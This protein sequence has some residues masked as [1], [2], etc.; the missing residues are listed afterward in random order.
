MDRYSPTPTELEDMGDFDDEDMNFAREVLRSYVD[1]GGLQSYLLTEGYSSMPF[2]KYVS[3]N[4]DGVLRLLC[5]GACPGCPAA[6]IRNVCN[7]QFGQ[8]VYAVVKH[9]FSGLTGVMPVLTH[10]PDFQ[11]IAEGAGGR[12]IN[13]CDRHKKLPFSIQKQIMMDWHPDIDCFIKIFKH[14]GIGPNFNQASMM[15]FDEA[16]S[17]YNA[18]FV[19]NQQFKCTDIRGKLAIKEECFDR[20]FLLPEYTV[21]ADE[22]VPH[23]ML[24]AHDKA[25]WRS[26]Q[27]VTIVFN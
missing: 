13:T 6:H 3:Y 23:R 9:K 22:R 21:E 4:N 26:S 18:C 5:C 16:A 1:D 8:M 25:F 15:S 14:R 11:R 10:D 19:V 7:V 27:Y 12:I 24:M 2:V 20:G 17:T